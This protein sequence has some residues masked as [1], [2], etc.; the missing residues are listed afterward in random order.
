MTRAAVPEPVGPP[1]EG[2]SVEELDGRV[3]IYIPTSEQVLYL[4]E[5]ATR[6]WRL[7]D[8]RRSAAQV[9]A[10]IAHEYGRAEDDVASDVRRVLGDLDAAGVFPPSCVTSGA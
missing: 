5:T 6:V 8:G 10:T 1:C 9:V 2:V 3:A 7:C 4:N